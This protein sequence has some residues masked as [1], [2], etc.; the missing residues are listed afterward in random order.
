MKKV[1]RQ[2]SNPS[3]RSFPMGKAYYDGTTQ[4]VEW[5]L[6]QYQEKKQ[7][8]TRFLEKYSYLPRES[9]HAI[10]F[11]SGRL[12]KGSLCFKFGEAERLE[13]GMTEKNQAW[14]LIQG[15]IRTK[16]SD[17]IHIGFPLIRFRKNIPSFES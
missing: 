3:D 9:L 11:T 6:E 16:G 14:S 13:S 10:L 12:P 15:Y 2:N 17:A 7:T 1:K 4:S 5:I 8:E